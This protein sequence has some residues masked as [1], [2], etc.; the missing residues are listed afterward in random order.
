MPQTYIRRP[1]PPP[2][3]LPASP[4]GGVVQAQTEPRT[5]QAGNL[6]SGP[7]SHVVSLSA[8]GSAP[9][10]RSGR[11][12]SLMP[13]TGTR[14]SAEHRS[15]PGS[16]GAGR[17]R[18]GH[19]G[20]RQGEQRD[21]GA[22]PRARP[23]QVAADDQRPGVVGTAQPRRPE[24]SC[25]PA[26]RARSPRR[27]SVDPGRTGRGER[28]RKKATRG[29][30]SPRLPAAVHDHVRTPRRELVLGERA[31]PSS[32][33]ARRRDPRRAGG[34]GRTQDGSGS[35]RRSR[36]RAA[37]SGRSPRDRRSALGREHAAAVEQRG[38]PAVAGD[39]RPARCRP[40]AGRARRSGPGCPGQW[41]SGGTHGRGEELVAHPGEDQPGRLARP[42]QSST[43]TVHMPVPSGIGR[44][45]PSHEGYG[46]CGGRAAGIRSAARGSRASPREG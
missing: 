16:R 11:N 5:G 37:R 24:A 28:G 13:T 29:S 41:R 9:I 3:G 35:G 34:R 19:A 46:A 33:A 4:G 25:P 7:R 27:G 32:T 23:G 36:T 43:I 44:D 6:R 17:S 10:S 22:A 14:R 12:R 42:D 15:G 40:P 26:P 8:T 39:R 2:G 21:R 30:A 18:S 31:R 38:R 45:G 1:G 20:R